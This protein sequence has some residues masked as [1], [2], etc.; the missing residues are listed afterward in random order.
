M[1]AVP[2]ASQSQG[3]ASVYAASPSTCPSVTALPSASPAATSFS[4]TFAPAAPVLWSCRSDSISLSG[5]PV[6]LEAARSAEGE[7]VPHIRVTDAAE[8]NADED[9]GGYSA[10]A[11]HSATGE[12][13]SSS[14][15][16][17]K[18]R[19][20]PRCPPPP[21]PPP[22]CL[23]VRRLEDRSGSRLWRW[24]E[25]TR[26]DY[27][28]PS[29]KRRNVMPLLQTAHGPF[30]RFSDRPW[31]ST[32]P[33]GFVVSPPPTLGGGAATPTGP[34][35]LRNASV[36]LSPQRGGDQASGGQAG[37]ESAVSEDKKAARQ[38]SSKGFSFGAAGRTASF[39]RT[40]TGS[41]TSEEAPTQ[42]AERLSGGR[43]EGTKLSKYNWLRVIQR[44][45]TITSLSARST[46]R[47]ASWESGINVS[48]TPCVKR[49]SD[50]HPR[51]GVWLAAP[52]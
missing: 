25:D 31:A 20:G 23:F 51:D 45:E 21:S 33:H 47:S 19:G 40:L 32:S 5:T 34:S 49:R 39:L 1:A 35:P 7:H 36:E 38:E 28:L 15:G 9:T 4:P 12:G 17:P 29:Q 27:T 52:F 10:P 3:P 43:T 22:L 48:S 6:S 18:L 41:V 24:I 46:P 8:E 26:I 14:A 30:C 50:S 42:H 37:T 44:K 2:Q 16:P 13:E 11:P